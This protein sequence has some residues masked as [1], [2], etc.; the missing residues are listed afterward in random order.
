LA[1]VYP[2]VSLLLISEGRDDLFSIFPRTN[3]DGGYVTGSLKR[4]QNVHDLPTVKPRKEGALLKSRLQKYTD[5]SEHINRGL[6]HKADG[7]MHTPMSKSTISKANGMSRSF[8]K[9]TTNQ[10]PLVTYSGVSKDLGD[11]LRDVPNGSFHHLATFT[12]TTT[13]KRMAH[14]FAA[15]KVWGDTH[16]HVIR[17][18]LK[19]G[20]G[21]SAVQ[22][23]HY[24]ENEVL[25]DKGTKIEKIKTELKP[26]SHGGKVWVHH[27]VAHPEKLPLDQYHTHKDEHHSGGL[28]SKA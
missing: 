4:W 20:T 27:V 13:D 5:S 22:H 8:T 18:H 24:N 23:S 6:Y 25:L 15:K 7:W 17:F 2:P 28:I 26:T 19:P 21:L 16:A 3:G 10:T 14:S 11:K 12:S 1:E 9:D